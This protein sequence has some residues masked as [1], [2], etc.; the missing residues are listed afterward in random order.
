MFRCLLNVTIKS[1]S[2]YYWPSVRSWWLDIGWV[3]FLPFYDEVEVHKNVLHTCLFSR[4]ENA[5]VIVRAPISWLDK[6]RKYNHLIGYIQISNSKPLP[7]L[8]LTLCFYFCFKTRFLKFINIFVFILIDAFGFPVFW[9]HKDREI[10][11]TL[12]TFAENNFGNLRKLSCTRL[13]FCLNF[14]C[15]IEA[16]S[17]RWAISLDLAR[18]GSQS[19][20]RI[21]RILPAR[22]A[23][24][25]IMIDNNIKQ[26]PKYHCISNF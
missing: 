14:T 12:F 4:T 6:R 20:Q 13:N 11:K 19:E 7:H 1:I 2:I 24:H 17:P 16:G 21:R 5:K 9:F 15:G 18:S 25:I 26:T 3:L 10:T 8:Y 22:G 23:C